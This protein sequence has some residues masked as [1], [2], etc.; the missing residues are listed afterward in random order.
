MHGD[1]R[2]AGGVLAALT[3]TALN[4]IS[5][6]FLQARWTPSWYADHVLALLPYVALLA[7][8]LWL[9]SGSVSVERAAAERRR[10]G[11]DIAKAMARETDPLLVVDQLLAGVL[12][13]LKADRVTIL[14]LVSQGYVVERGVDR[15]ARPASVG[16]VLPLGSVVAG[17]REVVREAVERMRP[18]V[19]GAYRVIGLDAAGQRHAGIL[20]TV[21]MPLARAGSVEWVLMAGRRVDKPFTH[22]DVD[23]LQE[24]GAI[25]ALLIHNAHLLAE[26][27]SLSRAKSN[28]INL[29]AHELGTPISVIRGYAEML[30]DESLG[31]ITREQRAPVDTIRAT[32]TDLAQ[33]VDELLLASRLAS[34]ERPAVEQAPTVD[35]VAAARA[36]RDRAGDRAALLGAKLEIRAPARAVLVAAG[37]RDL[38]VILDNLLNNAMTYSRAPAHVVVEVREA[39]SPEARVIDNGIGVPEGDWERIFDQFYRVDDTDFGYPAGTGLGLYISRELAVRYGARLFL[40]RSDRTGSVFTLRLRRPS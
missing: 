6:L 19:I 20:Q 39:G 15:E 9:Y 29:A 21:V 4:S 2:I 25:A 14:R 7:G 34:V 12:E 24:L 27:E 37:E 1:Q 17:T 28:F 11:L 22:T 16:S 3:F 8:Q 18:L 38:A 10:I 23:Q 30:A 32:S 33:R 35:L 13:A 40:E 31:P 36:A 5:L 26:S